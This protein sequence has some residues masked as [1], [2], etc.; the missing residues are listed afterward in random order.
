VFDSQA[1]IVSPDGKGVVLYV[2]YDNEFG[3]TKQVIRLG[4]VR[5]QSEQ[6]Y[7]LLINLS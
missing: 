5:G 3:Y 7:L 6:K 4:E 2:W 1:T